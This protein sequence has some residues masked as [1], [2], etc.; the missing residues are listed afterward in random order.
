ML[1]HWGCESS[2]ESAS[3]NNKDNLCELI[4]TVGFDNPADSIGI[5]DSDNFGKTIYSTFSQH[6]WT[7]QYHF[8]SVEY[9]SGELN[10][11]E[12][13]G[14]EYYYYCDFFGGSYCVEYYFYPSSDL[15]HVQVEDNRN[16]WMN[17]RFEEDSDGEDS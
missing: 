1:L 17:D 11:L 3:D 5:L 14:C 12:W 6:Y 8:M 16:E 13:K 9:D 15:F 7:L 2:Y 10:L 4:V